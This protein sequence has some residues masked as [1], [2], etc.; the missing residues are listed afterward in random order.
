MVN[1]PA[2]LVNLLVLGVQLP[3]Q[4][5]VH[6]PVDAERRLRAQMAGQDGGRVRGA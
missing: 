3:A 2:L 1:L 4:I 6:L 5:Q